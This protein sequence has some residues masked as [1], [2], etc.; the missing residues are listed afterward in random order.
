[1]I[2]PVDTKL[3]D[4]GIRVADLKMF[5]ED[6]IWSCYSYDKVNIGEELAMFSQ[7]GFP[8]VEESQ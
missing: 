3:I 8:L 2:K 5:E 1:M 7:K 6:K 4:A